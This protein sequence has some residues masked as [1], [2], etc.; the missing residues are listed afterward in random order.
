MALALTCVILILLLRLWRK[1]PDLGD[2]ASTKKCPDCDQL[3]SVDSF[4][5]S[6]CRRCTQGFSVH[7]YWLNLCVGSRNRVLYI[8]FLLLQLLYACCFAAILLA[9]LIELVLVLKHRQSEAAWTAK[10]ISGLA[11]F[12]TALALDCVVGLYAGKWCI[13]DLCL[14][15]QSSTINDYLI[16][17]KARKEVKR[18]LERNKQPNQPAI[19]ESR[20]VPVVISPGSELPGSEESS[21]KRKSVRDPLQSQMSINDKI[22]TNHAR[23]GRTINKDKRE[24][25]KE[26]SVIPLPDRK[27]QIEQQP[28]IHRMSQKK[29]RKPLPKL[30]LHPSRMISLK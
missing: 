18:I 16:H 23:P 7:S 29:N 22:E 17:I 21:M 26:N 14:Y 4:H 6:L 8:I 1:K 15:C 25:K 5:C 10:R 9:S 12:S 11:L 13:I 2:Q 20:S 30:C 27:Y 24:K 28:S 19:K 3:V